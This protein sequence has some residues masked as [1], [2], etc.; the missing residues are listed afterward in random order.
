MNS[1][2]DIKVFLI[3]NKAD[4]EER[5]EV[6]KEVAQKYKEDYDLDYFLETSAK[7][8]MNAQEIFIQAAK[9]LYKDYNL[10]HKNEKKNKEKTDNN[11]KI[12]IQ[13]QNE[14][15]SKKKCC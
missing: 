1:S 4:L 6:N 5:R 9:I 3:G 13:A 8:G 14:P 2:P 11:K 7:T 12:S 15:K 10:Y